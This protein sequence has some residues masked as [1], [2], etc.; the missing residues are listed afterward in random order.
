MKID[1]LPPYIL[2]ALRNRRLSDRA[3]ELMDADEAF[4]QYCMW[5]G[6]I[7]WGQQLRLVMQRL[8]EA[9]R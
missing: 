5:H 8:K 4:D 7:G 6:L 3:I 9:E 2:E 1:K